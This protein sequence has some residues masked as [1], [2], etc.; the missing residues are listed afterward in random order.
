MVSFNPCLFYIL[1][2]ITFIEVRLPDHW[3]LISNL[4]K[5]VCNQCLND[6]ADDLYINWAEKKSCDSIL[7]SSFSI[8]VRYLLSYGGG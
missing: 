5:L 7:S 6:L 8:Q 4:V 1:A 3:L 2:L